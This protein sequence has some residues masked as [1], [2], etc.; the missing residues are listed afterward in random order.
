MRPFTKG[1]HVTGRADP[2][3]VVIQ[4]TGAGV[5]AV[6]PQPACRAWSTIAMVK[7]L[8]DKNR[9]AIRA[10]QEQA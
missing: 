8:A 1:L 7:W 5:V 9:V 10:Y 3:R 2:A 6:L 4:A